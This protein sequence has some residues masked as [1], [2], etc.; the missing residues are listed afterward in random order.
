[1]TFIFPS[2]FMKPSSLTFQTI[3]LLFYKSVATTNHLSINRFNIKPRKNM[4][5]ML[6]LH[7]FLTV[8][9]PVPYV[10]QLKKYSKISDSVKMQPMTI[11][12]LAKNKSTK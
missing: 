8:K 5:P 10:T 4:K 12:V 11:E 7:F 3:Q 2:N 9:N 6:R 1:M